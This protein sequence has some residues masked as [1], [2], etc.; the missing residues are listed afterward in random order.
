M[1]AK[2]LLGFFLFWL[3]V[4]DFDKILVMEK[5]QAAEYGPPAKLLENKDGI[6]TSLVASTGTA[7]AA[8]LRSRAVAAFDKIPVEK[9]PEFEGID[10]ENL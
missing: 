1:S 3:P 4:I 5:G 7:S 2:F 10:W 8:E 6:F 9:Q